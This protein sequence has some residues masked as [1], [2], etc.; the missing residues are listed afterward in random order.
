MTCSAPAFAADGRML[1]W[2]GVG[3][4]LPL[5]F[6]LLRL[7]TNA[8]YCGAVEQLPGSGTEGKFP[9]DP[10]QVLC[11]ALRLAPP[12]YSHTELKTAYPG[13]RFEV[14]SDLALLCTNSE[15]SGPRKAKFE[16]IAEL[17]AA[18]QHF[19]SVEKL[20]VCVAPDGQT[21]VAQRIGH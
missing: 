15:N 19:T 13:K 18:M 3:S 4:D 6:T 21:V 2:E 10:V 20:E 11:R 8:L 16:S 14:W 1:A 5:G 9:M 12:S 7:E 17:A